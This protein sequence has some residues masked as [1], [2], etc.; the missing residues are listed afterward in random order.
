MNDDEQ[1]AKNGLSIEA[2][3]GARRKVRKAV[4]AKRMFVSRAPSGN[5]PI[6]SAASR[7]THIHN[8]NK[9]DVIFVLIFR[10]LS[11]CFYSYLC[12]LIRRAP[13]EKVL[14]EACLPYIVVNEQLFR[15]VCTT[16]V[17]GF[18]TT[19]RTSDSNIL[20]LIS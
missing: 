18:P 12:L 16:T 9:I 19:R 2:L 7:L 15:A 3:G 11:G 17:K 8:I 10:H 6:Y 1:A 4:F 13:E 14:P 5:L 20:L